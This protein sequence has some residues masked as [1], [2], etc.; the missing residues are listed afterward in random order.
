MAQVTNWLYEMVEELLKGGMPKIER[1]PGA[2]IRINGKSSSI[3]FYRLPM[4]LGGN[5]FVTDIVWI[6]RH[7]GKADAPFDF[8]H[9]KTT[10]DKAKHRI[11]ERMVEAAEHF[12]IRMAS[13]YGSCK[14]VDIPCRSYVN[15]RYDCQNRGCVFNVNFNKLKNEENYGKSD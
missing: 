1:L 3:Y 4:P 6:H 13:P 2:G 10:S 12:H 11:M 8:W 7:G 14:R 9:L 15:H 5:R